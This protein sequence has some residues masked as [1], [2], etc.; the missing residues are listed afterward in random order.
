MPRAAWREK[1]MRTIGVLAAMMFTLSACV[2]SHEVTPEQVAIMDAADEA[3]ATALFDA[4]VDAATSY[5][6]HK[7]GFVVIRFAGSV[8]GHVYTRVVSELRADPRITGVRAEQG[9][10]E[11]CVL[12]QGRGD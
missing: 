6:I 5:N 10:R 11:V 8:P 4:E 1:N 12:R 9:G 7:D 2:G 3:V